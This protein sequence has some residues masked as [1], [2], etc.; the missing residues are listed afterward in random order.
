MGQLAVG[1]PAG[2]RLVGGAGGEGV[3]GKGWRKGR[4]QGTRRGP[5]SFQ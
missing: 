3:E 2:Q 5:F 4:G 1:P